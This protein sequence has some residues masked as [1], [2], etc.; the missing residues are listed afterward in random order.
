MRKYGDM[1]RAGMGAEAIL[2]ML[3]EIDLEEL[4]QGASRMIWKAQRVRKK[5]EL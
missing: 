3:R 1:F 4:Y 5:S 2:E